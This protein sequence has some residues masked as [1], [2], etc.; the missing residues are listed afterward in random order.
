MTY[1]RSWTRNN[2]RETASCNNSKAKRDLIV[3]QGR[4]TILTIAEVAE[5]IGAR[6]VGDGS[7]AIRGVNA[8]DQAGPAEI[9]FATSEKHRPKLAKSKA[10]A[11]IV[12]KKIE[13]VAVA[14]L[15]VDNVEAALIT[16]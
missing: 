13:N 6:L 11:V 1:S 16:D 8:I 9:S 7:P 4:G 3:K 12:G 2:N 5:R 10:A 15:V 14:Q